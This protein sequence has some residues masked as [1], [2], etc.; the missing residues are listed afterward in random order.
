M[1]LLLIRHALPERVEV[2]AGAADPPLSSEGQRQAA[3][4]AGWLGVEAI[5]A[6]YAS[7]LRRA[8]E[9]ATAVALPHQLDIDVEDGIAEFDRH[10]STYIPAEELDRA[11]LADVA[12]GRWDDWGEDPVSLRAR[13]VKAVEGIIEANPSR[14]VAVVC[15]AAVINAYVGHVLEVG[16]PM[17]FEPGYTSVSRVLASSRGHRHVHTLNEGAHLRCS[18]S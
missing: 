3:A 18:S 11:T 9:T 12:A 7:P 2:V 1:E 4:L 13:T 17:I 5:D 15:H 8:W 6:V 10:S 16:T 14:R